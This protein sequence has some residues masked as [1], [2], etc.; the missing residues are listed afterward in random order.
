MDTPTGGLIVTVVVP[1][2][3]GQALAVAVTL[4]RPEAATLA[5]TIVG[6]W[7]VEVN[8]SGP[9]QLYVAP[10]TVEA[11][12]LRVEPESIGPLL[13]AVGAAGMSFTTATVMPARELQPLAV[14]VTL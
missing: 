6:F 2:A 5:L 10:G 12:R 3:E 13:P 4:Y 11:V 1:A 8:P 9:V 14:A 7:L